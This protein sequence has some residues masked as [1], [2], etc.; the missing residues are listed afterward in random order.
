MNFWQAAWFLREK[1]G[2]LR[3]DRADISY[4]PAISGT[5][6][7]QRG[8]V[9]Y[10]CDE[11][12]CTPDW[13]VGRYNPAPE[14]FAEWALEDGIKKILWPSSNPN[15]TRREMRS[16]FFHQDGPPLL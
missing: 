5:L 12:Y 13:K 14:T 7:T 10:F 16:E 11:D 8:A 1:V 4:R 6:T 15:K 3:W 2:K 9:K